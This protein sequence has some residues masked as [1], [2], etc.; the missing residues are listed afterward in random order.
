MNKKEKT[1]PQKM[2]LPLLIAVVTNTLVYKC[3]QMVSMLF[4][5]DGTSYMCLNPHDK[6]ARNS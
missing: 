5:C 4:T 3:S 1:I 2:R 6:V